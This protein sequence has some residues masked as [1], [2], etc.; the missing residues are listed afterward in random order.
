MHS[1]KYLARKMTPLLMGALLSA[2][3]LLSATLFLETFDNNANGWA[4]SGVGYTFGSDPGGSGQNVAYASTADNGSANTQLT[5]ANHVSIIDE[6]LTLDF[7]VRV[8]KI[9]EVNSLNRFSVALSEAGSGRSITFD[10]RPG[11]QPS[12]LHYKD[13]AGNGWTF[14]YGSV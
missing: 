10:I 4:D 14:N 3:A 7:S 5:L 8:D 6:G 11:N 2:P 1:M 12:R 13:S 9:A